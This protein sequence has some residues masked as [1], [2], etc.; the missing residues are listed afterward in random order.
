MDNR[1][2]KY[3]LVGIQRMD[4]RNI[5]VYKHKNQLH[6]VRNRLRLHHMVLDSKHEL[7]H[8]YEEFENIIQRIRAKRMEL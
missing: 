8:L 5:Q 3:I 6:R 7:V 4:H 1:Y 2:S